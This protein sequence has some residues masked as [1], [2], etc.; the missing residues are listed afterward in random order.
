MEDRDQN[1]GVGPTCSAEELGWEACSSAK[2]N[3]RT[4]S[5]VEVVDIIPGLFCNSMPT[6]L[7][8]AGR[9][10]HAVSDLSCAFKLDG[11]WTLNPVA[12]V[13]DIRLSYM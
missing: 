10:I 8:R 7:L 9:R 3:S 5:L 13:P 6:N 11:P 2:L 1:H 12:A 4:T